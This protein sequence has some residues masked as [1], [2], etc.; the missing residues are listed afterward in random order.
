MPAVTLIAVRTLYEDT[1]IRQTLGEHLAADI[2]Q[3][4]TLADVS[5]GLLDHRVTIH[6]GQQAE[7]EALRVAWIGETIHSYTRLRRMKR[8]AHSRV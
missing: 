7:A 5:P 3:S 1:R 6:I 2:I 4:D 8:L